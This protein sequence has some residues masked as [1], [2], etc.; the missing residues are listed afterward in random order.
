MKTRVTLTAI[1]WMLAKSTFFFTLTP[2]IELLLV[3]R[4]IQGCGAAGCTALSQA[5]LRDLL[6]PAARER[7]VG[8]LVAV[9]SASPLLAPVLGSLLAASFGWRATFAFLVCV[10]LTALVGVPL[11]ST[12]VCLLVE[13]AF[14]QLHTALHTLSCFRNPKSFSWLC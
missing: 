1:P 12:T 2:S 8:K 11:L 6:D 14:F 13:A 4:I 7:V 5:I 3:L 10:Y 9:R